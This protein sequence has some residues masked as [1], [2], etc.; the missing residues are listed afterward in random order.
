MCLLQNRQER[1]K[2]RAIEFQ[3]YV[4]V[5]P[6]GFRLLLIEIWLYLESESV[7]KKYRPN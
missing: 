4:H 3:A 5:A 1:F 2:Y 6:R 7:L